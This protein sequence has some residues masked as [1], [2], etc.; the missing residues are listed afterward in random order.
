VVLR[1]RLQ[2]GA[3]LGGISAVVAGEL[4]GE[5]AEV[6]DAVGAVRRVAGELHDGIDSNRVR[7]ALETGGL[8]SAVTMAVSRRVRQRCGP[9]CSLL[10]MG[11]PSHPFFFRGGGSGGVVV[12]LDM[13]ICTYA[14]QFVCLLLN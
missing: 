2:V 6:D 5:R 10:D 7:V 11:P 13:C 12:L 14:C 1:K 8:I 3:E 4:T 9:Y